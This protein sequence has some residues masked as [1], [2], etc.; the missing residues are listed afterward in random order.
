MLMIRK[1]TMSLNCDDPEKF[2]WALYPAFLS[3]PHNLIDNVTLDRC[4][5][6]NNLPLCNSRIFVLFVLLRIKWYKMK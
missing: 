3:M 5:I 2:P 4:T 6:V 1:R